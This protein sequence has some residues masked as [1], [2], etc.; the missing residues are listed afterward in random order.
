MEEK[1]TKYY[2][3]VEKTVAKSDDTGN[4]FLFKDG[5][6]IKDEE[7]V[8]EDHP[9][10][11]DL[12]ESKTSPRRFGRNCFLVEMEIISEEEAVLAVNQQIADDLKE[13]WKEKFRKKKEEWDKAPIW[14]AKYVET[15][16]R[17]NGIQY[18]IKPEDIGLEKDPWDEGFMESIQRDIEED[19][20]RYGADE[21]RS[22]G[23]LD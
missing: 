7:A 15:V 22:T 18:S 16:F 5:K 14:P 6:W 13:L 1:N 11:Y 3:V 20:K 23:F 8:F 10:E 9:A 21:I 19:L 17:L 2:F 4:I 12:S